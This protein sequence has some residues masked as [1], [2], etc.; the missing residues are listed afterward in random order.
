MIGAVVLIVV[1]ATSGCISSESVSAA[2]IKGFTLD[3]VEDVTSYRYTMYK[4]FALF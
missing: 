4:A 2:E 3:S 1:A